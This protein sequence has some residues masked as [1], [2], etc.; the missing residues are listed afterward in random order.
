MM[1]YKIIWKNYKCHLKNYIAFFAC[2]IC[3]V[4]LFF[5]FWAIQNTFGKNPDM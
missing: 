5:A 2:S 4:A 1:L 3:N